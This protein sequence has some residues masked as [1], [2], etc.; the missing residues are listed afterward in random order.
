MNRE[1][2]FRIYDGIEMHME[3]PTYL[4][5]TASMNILFKRSEHIMQFTGLKDKNGVEVYEGDI[6]RILYTDWPS[7][8]QED[9]RT[10][11]QYMIDIASIGEVVFVDDSWM[12]LLKNKDRYG[13]P[14]MGFINPGTRGYIEVIGNIHEHK[15]LLQ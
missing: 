7:K 15:N 14:Y 2:K 5:P 3:P 1:I 12:I 11:D 13:D 9:P 8:S 4:I 10:I 6:V